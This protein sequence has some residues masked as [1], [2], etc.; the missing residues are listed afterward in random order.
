MPSTSSTY[1]CLPPATEDRPDREP[2]QDST[3]SITPTPACPYPILVELMNFE[4]LLAAEDQS[5]AWAHPHVRFRPYAAIYSL[6][7][8]WLL[9]SPV[10]LE[11]EGQGRRRKEGRRSELGVI[12]IFDAPQYATPLLTAHKAE[13]NQKP[14]QPSKQH[15]RVILGAYTRRFHHCELNSHRAVPS[16]AHQV[17]VKSFALVTRS[18]STPSVTDNGII[19]RS[20]TDQSRYPS[21]SHSRIPVLAADCVYFEPAFPLLVATLAAGDGDEATMTTS[22]TATGQPRQPRHQLSSKTGFGGPGYG[23]DVVIPKRASDRTHT[24]HRLSSNCSSSNDGRHSR[25]GRAAHKMG[26]KGNAEE[27]DEGTAGAMEVDTEED[28][29]REETS[30]QPNIHK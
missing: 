11:A 12:A 23:Y 13:P 30:Y 4:C 22:A 26:R 6:A 24:E 14:R 28:I 15:R 19:R 8:S 27:V 7:R 5:E 25:A 18:A 21:T 17:Q 1:E 10:C 9:L 2:E 20:Y 29:G 16:R 3:L